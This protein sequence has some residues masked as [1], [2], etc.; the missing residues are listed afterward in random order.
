MVIFIAAFL[1]IFCTGGVSAFSVFSEALQRTSGGSASQVAFA[2][3]MNLFFLA[4]IG[5][6][7]GRIADRHSPKLLMYLGGICLGA[8]W[9]LSAV[10][11]NPVL[12]CLTFGFLAG[13][14]EGLVYNPC[15]TLTLRWFPEK[16]ATMSGILLAAASLGPITIAKAGVWLL[17]LVGIYGLVAIG[18]LFFVIIFAFGWLIEAP[19][20]NNSIKTG[21]SSSEGKKQGEYT[22]REMVRTAEFWITALLY[23]LAATSGIMMLGT[24]STISQVQLGITAAAA[25]NL[26]VVNCLSNFAGRSLVGYVCDRL[27]ETKTLVILLIAT[28]LALYGMRASEDLVLFTVCLIVNGFSF[29]GILV[30]FPPLTSRLFGLKNSGINYGI[31]FMAYSVA[32]LFAPQI[33]TRAANPELGTATYSSAFMIA[34]C[35][36]FA[37]LLVDL[38]LI[39]VMSKKGRD[40]LNH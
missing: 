18:A 6:F 36:A 25:A 34:I 1:I 10:V 9:A 27:G 29:G 35:V 39:H 16:R 19:R 30:V 37:G 23:M 8:G 26:V 12:L 11:R 32:A 33:S 24:L 38:F 28:C 40:R 2:Y 17:E 31:V 22:P 7:S 14:G 4:F 13:T 20:S 5:I 15:I 3:S 21:S